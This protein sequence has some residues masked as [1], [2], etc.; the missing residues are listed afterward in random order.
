MVK[1]NTKSK[2]KSNKHSKLTHP[3]V[4]KVGERWQPISASGSIL[5]DVAR[6]G[7]KAGY[8]SKWG[9]ENAARKM[10]AAKKRR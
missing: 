6:N 4:K 5:C 3:M 8:A 7:D 1:K 2:S 10:A 9:A